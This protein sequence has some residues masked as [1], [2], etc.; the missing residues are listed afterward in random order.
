MT[1][2]E[3]EQFKKLLKKFCSEDLDQW[4]RWKTETNFGTVYISIS[5]IPDFRD[6]F[7]YEWIKN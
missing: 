5:R 4:E 1:N 2:E 6:G 7:G 3:F